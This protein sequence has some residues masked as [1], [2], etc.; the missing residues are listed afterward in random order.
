MDLGLPQ[1]L[2]AWWSLNAK[3]VLSLSEGLVRSAY[4]GKGC[5]NPAMPFS[6][7]NANGVASDADTTLR[8][9]TE[10][11]RNAVGVADRGAG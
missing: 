11:G 1:A 3:G 5:I 10:D 2:W 9:T 7:C 4:P 6:Q 8:P